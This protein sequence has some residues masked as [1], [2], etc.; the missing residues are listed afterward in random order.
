[1]PDQF[2]LNVISNW[3]LFPLGIAPPRTD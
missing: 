1:M 3:G 2:K